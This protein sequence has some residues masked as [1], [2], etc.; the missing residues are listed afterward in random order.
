MNR[1]RAAQTR[2]DDQSEGGYLLWL[3]TTGHGRCRMMSGVVKRDL[4]QLNNSGRL[5]LL[6]KLA[7]S[8]SSVVT[9]RCPAVTQVSLR[10]SQLVL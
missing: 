4:I 5:T 2:G 8:P 6:G 3:Q 7:A 10:E 9:G 1:Q